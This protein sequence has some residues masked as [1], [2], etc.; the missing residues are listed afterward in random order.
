LKRILLCIS[1]SLIA[2]FLVWRLGISTDTEGNL[3]LAKTTNDPPVGQEL[4]RNSP[5]SGSL[6]RGDSDQDELRARYQSVNSTTG[7]QES[8]KKGPPPVDPETAALIDK[9]LS[10]ADKDDLIANV[11]ALAR[12]SQSTQVTD[13]LIQILRD[14][15][16]K[17]RTAALSLLAARDDARVLAVLSDLAFSDPSPR[18]RGRAAQL[19]E[20]LETASQF[21]TASEG[22]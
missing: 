10:A 18:I 22:D 17:V 6:L 5:N 13:V 14:E 9:V 1:L 12:S 8:L 4:D 7:D 19:V 11:K 20:Y 2:A 21:A 15:N 3:S 16:E